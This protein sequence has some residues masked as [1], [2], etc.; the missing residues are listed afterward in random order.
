MSDSQNAVGETSADAYRPLMSP[1]RAERIRRF[2]EAMV[3]TTKAEDTETTSLFGLTFVVPPE[4]KRIGPLSQL[5]GEAVLAEVKRGDRVLDMGTGCGV[6]AVIAATKAT[7]VLAV[8]INPH[9]MKTTHDNALRNGLD[10]RI[11]VRE[12]D[13]F[14]NVDGTFDLIVFNPPFRW[15]APN[16]MLE[17]AT[18]D[19][20]Y[21]ALTRFFREARQYL[22]KQ[23]RMIIFFSN[24]GD[25]AY[26][27]QLI[28]TEGFR[29]EVVSQ[30]SRVVE[31]LDINFFVFRLS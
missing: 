12:S 10:D 11:E 6:N 1:E 7:D 19:E 27:Q 30:V 16:T 5:L 25:L 20:N 15:F 14:S 3:N 31:G 23:G 18:S 9:C 8:D 28:D 13:I 29:Q 24:A 2:H 21:Q 22:A 17:A 4:V 26:L